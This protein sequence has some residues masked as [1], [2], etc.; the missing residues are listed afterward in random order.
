MDPLDES[1]LDRIGCS[2][3]ELTQD[4]R[5]I[6]GQRHGS[7]S[8]RTPQLAIDMPLR[9]AGTRPPPNRREDKMANRVRPGSGRTL[10]EGADE[11]DKRAA[12]GFAVSNPGFGALGIRPDIVRMADESDKRRTPRDSPRATLDQSSLDRSSPSHRGTSA[13][14]RASSRGEGLELG[15]HR[16]SV[17]HIVDLLA[18]LGAVPGFGQRPLV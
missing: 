1:I 10:S 9:S 11:P 18:V 17:A 13:R 15:D 14:R 4:V 5:G 3:D 12:S 16:S 8:A 7:P 6:A 2:V